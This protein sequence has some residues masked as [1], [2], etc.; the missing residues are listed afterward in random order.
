MDKANQQKLACVGLI[1]L[2]VGWL[3]LIVRSSG[4]TV[5]SKETRMIHIYSQ[6]ELNKEDK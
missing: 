3:W 4:D 1:L 6:N 2:T 5:M